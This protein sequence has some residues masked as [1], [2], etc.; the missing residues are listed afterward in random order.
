MAGRWE[1]IFAALYDPI[2]GVA[3]RRGMAARRAAVVAQAS[4]RTV[5]LGAGTGMNL[6]HYSDAV[7]ELILTEPAEPMARRLRA[8][9]D[10]ERPGPKVFESGAEALP[11]EDA[12][13]DSIVC[14]LVLCTVP[15]AAA[16]LREAERVLKPGGKM[17]LLEHVVG[18]AG[19]GEERVQRVVQ[20]PWK[21]F[22]VGCDCHRDTAGIVAAS[23]L[24]VESETHGRL[25]GM[26]PPVRPG[27]EAVLVRA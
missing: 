20:R 23:P 15:D 2:L 13:V 17:L 25:E 3:E 27:Y 26:F 12:S 16:V 7:T 22:A 8:R 9:V 4:G 21:A 11:L 14:T 10:Q 24:K 19:S 18:T 5:E 1:G 6:P